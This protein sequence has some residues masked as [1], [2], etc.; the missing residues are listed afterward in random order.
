MKFLGKAALA[1]TIFAGMISASARAD[2]IMQDPTVT[3][4][5]S[6]FTWS[7]P[8]VLTTNTQIQTGDF[9]VLYDFN[10]YVP[11]SIFAPANWSATAQLTTTPPPGISPL[12]P[13]NATVFNLRFEYTGTTTIVNSSGS[14]LALGNFGATSTLSQPTAG[15]FAAQTHDN[16][17][18]SLLAVN[19][20]FVA[21][22]VPEPATF[23]MAGIGLAGIGLVARRAR[24]A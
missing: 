23:V 11:G 5:G 8:V 2:I 10:G 17:F 22:P 4:S 12:A 13:D 7:Y 16:T 20:G 6:N 21:V 14:S 18:P 9:F 15:L 19:Q 1:A 24:K 3:T